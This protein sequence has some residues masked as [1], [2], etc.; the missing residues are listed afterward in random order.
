MRFL[1]QRLHTSWFITVWCLGFLI[2]ILL[3]GKI[4][5]VVSFLNSF[6]V[7]SLVISIILLIRC[8]L[9]MIPLAVV[10]GCLFGIWRGLFLK[11]ELSDYHSLYSQSVTVIGKVKDDV[12]VK[13]I[14]QMA[15]RLEVQSINGLSIPG[16]LYVTTKTDDI[17]R[18]D[19]VWLNGNLQGGFG[20]FTGVIYRANIEKIIQPQ[21]GNL[22]RRL[23]DWF[24]SKIRRLIPEPQASLGIGF[25]LGQRRS[26]SSDLQLALQVVGLTHIV[27]ASGYNLTILVRLC[28][29]LFSRLS[30]Y[31]AMISSIIII[32]GFISITGLSPSM[33]RAGIVTILSLLAWYY[34]RKF[35]P[36]VLLIL[37]MTITVLINP[38]YIW[39]DLGWQLSF[40][41]FAGVMILAPLMNNYFF[42][43]KKPNSIRQIL[44]ETLSA[45]IVT[46][47]IIIVSFGM[48]SNVAILANLLVLPFIPL[49]MLL[50][51]TT[52]LA[53]WLLVGSSF[54]AGL[55]AWPLKWLLDYML[56][57]INYLADFSWS[58]IQIKPSLLIPIIGY[59]LILGFTVYIYFKT[60][61]NLRGSN[62]IE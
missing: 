58:S 8:R 27:V 19:I 16:M 29:R 22:A 57:V 4:P 32:F 18:G 54:V 15:I 10:A 46:A 55:L 24:A 21:P 37:A 17:K 33:V 48:F 38:Y 23:R 2:G 30:K 11:L 45:Q 31:L 50:T 20:S 9:F 1:G 42:G 51:F 28:R 40:A 52:G 14:S 61:F 25:L 60:R 47:P 35:H 43:D 13:S 5:D 39:G 44:V 53:G 62:L 26:I 7:I 41:A 56:L 36:L 49:A 12:D 3:S 59:S 6:L 34:G